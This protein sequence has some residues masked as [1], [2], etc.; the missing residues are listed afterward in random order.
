MNK[1]TIITAIIVA[2]VFA[3]AGFFGGMK[4]QQRK[5]P[6]V[7]TRAPGTFGNFAEGN[8]AGRGGRTGGANGGAGFASGQILKVDSNSIT[9]QLP[10]NGGSKIV[11]YSTSTPIGE[12]K[13]GS[14]A[15]LTTGQNVLVTGTPNS[16]GSVTAQNI[17]IRPAMPPQDQPTSQTGN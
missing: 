16:D 9:V 10:N 3:G 7:V 11:F 6:A 2:I 15:D 17:Q 8:F 14:A 13:A 4:Y 5:T 12:M 1:N